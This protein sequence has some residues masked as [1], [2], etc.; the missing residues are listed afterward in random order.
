MVGFEGFE[1][2]SGMSQAVD[3]FGEEGAGDGEAVFTGAAGPVALGEQGAERDH[4]ADGNEEG[5]AVADG[6]DGGGEEG[7]ELVLEDV[8]ELG[9]LFGESE[10]HGV[11]GRKTGY[12]VLFYVPL[13]PHI[14]H[15]YSIK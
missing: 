14:T 6:A 4:G 1:E 10:S 9:E 2:L 15:L 13:I 7:E 5:G 3:A 11:K 8:G 12:L